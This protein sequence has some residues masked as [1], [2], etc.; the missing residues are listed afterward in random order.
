MSRV[1]ELLARTRREVEHR[2]PA[3]LQNVPGDDRRLRWNRSGFRIIAEIKR[4]SL[5]AG[6]IRPDLDL[7]PLARSYEAAGAAA[8]SVLTEPRFF[9]GSL[10]DLQQARS[11]V[12][13][14]LLQKDFLIDPF[15]VH[16]AKAHGAAF[17]LLI[18]RFLSKQELRGM[19]KTS[20]ELSVNAIVEITDEHDLEKLDEPIEFL[21]VNSRDLQTLEVDTAK[22]QKL[23]RLLPDAFLIAESGIHSTA[24]LEHVLGLGY[25]GALIGEHFL[26][27]ADPAGELAAF[28]RIADHKPRVKICGVTSEADALRAV[29][30]G[31]SALGFIFADSPR[32]IAP[33][34]LAAIRPKIP[35][36]ILCAGVF[37]GQ[38]SSEIRDTVRRFDLHMAQVYDEAPPDVP[39]WI[40]RRIQSAP[41]LDHP[42]LQRAVLW[43]VKSEDSRLRS[44]WESLAREPVFAIGGGLHPGNV[45]QAVE[46][47]RPVW[48]DV[49]RGVEKEPGVKD[50]VKLDLFMKAVQ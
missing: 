16:E 1:E 47:C 13:L 42:R 22:F 37:L 8:I 34:A 17:V 14:P 29:D 50:P 20:R 21:G 25:H 44:I 39:L 19:L 15:Q 9:G 11:A 43:D 26:R 33:E 7:Q 48:V 35:A 18:A 2:K 36:G 12:S 27:A 31:A 40:A 5:S 45:A 23:R 49:A 46:I 30:A 4:S 41:A 3:G 24:M 38:A 10:S 6:N 28:V 32:R